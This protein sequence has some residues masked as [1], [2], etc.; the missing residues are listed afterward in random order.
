MEGDF[1]AVLQN[2]YMVKYKGL[3]WKKFFCDYIDR[4]KSHNILVKD[5][6]LPWNYNGLCFESKIDNY[7]VICYSS[8][9][10]SYNYLKMILVLWHEELHIIKSNLFYYLNTEDIKISTNER[11]LDIFYNGYCGY[12]FN[13]LFSY[14]DD[15]NFDKIAN[16]YLE[17]IDLEY[18]F[19]KTI[20]QE[21]EYQNI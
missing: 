4:L 11:M 3:K 14:I 21:Y 13:V 18:V 7:F 15:P 12:I 2:K 1:F 20:D 8:K 19:S 9:R 17:S 10:L 6:N 5:I 16:K